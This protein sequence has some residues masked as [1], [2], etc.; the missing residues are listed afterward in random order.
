M[1]ERNIARDP[2]MALEISFVDVLAECL[3]ILAS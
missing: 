3:K 2:D 1:G